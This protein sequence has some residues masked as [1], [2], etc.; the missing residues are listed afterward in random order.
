MYLSEVAPATTPTDD[1]VASGKAKF[2]AAKAKRKSDHANKMQEFDRLIHKAGD[3]NATMDCA[4]K[5]LDAYNAKNQAIK[6]EEK[7]QQSEA[8]D[9]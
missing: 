8:A 2:E 5:A 1:P 6:N 7:A 9:A 4:S 3:K